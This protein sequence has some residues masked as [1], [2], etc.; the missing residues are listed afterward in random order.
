MQIA[1]CSAQ[2][3]PLLE[4]G[5]KRTIK[6]CRNSAV[7]KQ[8][9]CKLRRHR[10]WTV[11]AAFLREQAA[12]DTPRELELRRPKGKANAIPAK[13]AKAA[14]RLELAVGANIRRKEI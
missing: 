2:M 3:H 11:G 4:S 5:D 14:E 13:I 10:R 6:S 7:K 9:S 8:F 12:R 1:F